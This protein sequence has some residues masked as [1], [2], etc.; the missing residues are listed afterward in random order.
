[1]NTT[2][3]KSEASELAAMACGTKHPSKGA[4]PASKGGK[5]GAKR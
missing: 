1:M 4:K 5:K 2:A 3:R